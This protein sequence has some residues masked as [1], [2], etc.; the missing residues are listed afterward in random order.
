LLL[1]ATIHNSRD[2]LISHSNNLL[3]DWY[4][5]GEYNNSNFCKVNISGSDYSLCQV[6]NTSSEAENP[7]LQFDYM[8]FYY[9]HAALTKHGDSIVYMLLFVP[10]YL[11]HD[12][13]IIAKLVEH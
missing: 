3:F 10:K 6:F 7:K 12:A 5:R 2:F 4:L 1:T 13:H 9:F 11:E 8:K